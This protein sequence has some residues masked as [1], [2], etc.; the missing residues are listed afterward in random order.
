MSCHDELARADKSEYFAI[1]RKGKNAIEDL[2]EFTRDQAN[3]QKTL[4]AL[5]KTVSKSAD[6]PSL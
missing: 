6:T 3:F 1:P 5:A 2:E 4:E